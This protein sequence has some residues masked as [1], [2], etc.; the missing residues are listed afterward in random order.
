MVL[1]YTP[2][3]QATQ[4]AEIGRSSFQASLGKKKFVRPHL[5]VK[6]LAWCHTH[7]LI[8]THE[9]HNR[10]I[11]KVRPCLQN[12]RAKVLGIWRKW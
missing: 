9:A 6:S 4:E 2:V 8:A 10:R 5:N 3:T 7:V 11:T 1:Q 12:N